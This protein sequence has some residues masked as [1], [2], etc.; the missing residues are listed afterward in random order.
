MP[1]QAAGTTGWIELGDGDDGRE[2]CREREGG[3]GDGFVERARERKGEERRVREA[4]SLVR[5]A[6][7]SM[8]CAATAEAEE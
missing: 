3:G 2:I 4:T 6:G 8:R 5:F 1:D 7:R